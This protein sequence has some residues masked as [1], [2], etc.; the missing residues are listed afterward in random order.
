MAHDRQIVPTAAELA[1]WMEFQ[2]GLFR[3]LEEVTGLSTM[4]IIERF[5][6]AIRERFARFFFRDGIGGMYT[7]TETERDD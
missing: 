3:F 1:Q 5:S 6:P 2:R 4:A 7:E